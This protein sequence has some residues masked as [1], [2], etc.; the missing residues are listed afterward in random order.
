MA[1]TLVYLLK[2]G[3]DRIVLAGFVKVT[4]RTWSGSAGHMVSR[5]CLQLKPLPSPRRVHLQ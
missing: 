3:N 4:L 2:N 5:T 1:A